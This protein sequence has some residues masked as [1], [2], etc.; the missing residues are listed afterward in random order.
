M[1]QGGCTSD[2][3]VVLLV[4]A[5][6]V[7]RRRFGVVHEL[8]CV[9]VSYRTDCLVLVLGMQMVLWL[10]MPQRGTVGLGWCCYALGCNAR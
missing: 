10:F 2:F 3:S 8:C 6:V 7:A 4:G 5:L 1:P 9:S